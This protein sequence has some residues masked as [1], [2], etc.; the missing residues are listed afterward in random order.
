MEHSTISDADLEHLV[1]GA[2]VAGAVTLA[3]VFDPSPE[4]VIRTLATGVD[5]ILF[6][7][8]ETADQ[9]RAA[10]SSLRLPPAGVR[11]WATLT[12]A[13]GYYMGRSPAH[14]PFCA[15]QIETKEAVDNVDEIL[16]VEGVEMVFLGPG[17]L[18]SSIV[19]AGVAA[20][21]VDAALQ[22]A[23]ERV[24]ER[25]D[26]RSTPALGIPPT[27]PTMRWDREKSIGRGVRV[28][29]LGSDVAFLAGAAKK[30]LEDF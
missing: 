19:G 29:T 28:I 24:V 18:R 15:I 9:A 12:R 6:P 25:F 8:V 20:D 27:Y 7:M 16:A 11:G 17:D 2:A 10:V 23:I 14:E 26:G 21:E 22:T 30:A 13:A 5:G 3:R 4:S 1:R